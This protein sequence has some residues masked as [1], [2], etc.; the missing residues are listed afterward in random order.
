MRI[1]LIIL[2]VFRSTFSLKEIRPAIE[3]ASD[4]GDTDD[5]A[6]WINPRSPAQR[7]IIGTIKEPAPNGAL[8]VYALDGTV[9]ERVDNIDRPNNVDIQGDICVLTE[10]LKRQIRVYRISPVK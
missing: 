3:T 6:I 10:R 1:L 9:V 8:A 7:L 2:T 4:T 5:P